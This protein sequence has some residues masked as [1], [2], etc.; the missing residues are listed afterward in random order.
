MTDRRRT[1]EPNTRYSNNLKHKRGSLPAVN[2]SVEMLNRDSSVEF[3][4]KLMHP[5]KKGAPIKVIDDN[6]RRLMNQDDA[7]KEEMTDDF[8]RIK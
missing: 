6:M 8:Y 2:K 4:E 7:F 3:M 1:T 5:D